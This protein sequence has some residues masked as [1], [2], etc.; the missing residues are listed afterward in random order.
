M[1]NSVWGTPLVPIIKKDDSLRICADYKVTINK[2]LKDVK[3]PLPRI[4]ELFVALSS[5]E[6]FIKLDLTAA[7]NQLEV[8]KKLVNYWLG[9]LI[10]EFIYSNGYL[11]KPNQLVQFFRELWK[12]S[13]KV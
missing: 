7:Y 13:C 12:S 1:D 6:F 5:G 4:E 3:H 8:R 9:V 2:Y 11:L 10:S